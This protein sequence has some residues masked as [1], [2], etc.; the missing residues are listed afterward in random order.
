[1][2]TQKPRTL[3]RMLLSLLTIGALVYAGWA[4]V[5]WFK[6]DDLLFPRRLAGP[7]MPEATFPRDIQRLW[8]PLDGDDRRVT[9]DKPGGESIEAWLYLP[10]GLPADLAHGDKRPAVVF[11]HG[12]GELIDHMDDYARRWLARGFIVLIPEYRGYGR[13]AGLPG[14]D[15][16][17]AD[18]RLFADWLRHRPDVDPARLVYHGRSL[19]TGVV[20][21]LAAA[22]NTS[23][24]PR[25][26]AIV[27]E[28]PFTSVASFAAGFGIP[29]FLVKNP[30]RTDAVLPALAQSGVHVLIVHSPDDEIVHYKHGRRL[31]DITPSA[32]L[33]DLSG[34][35]ISN[36][37]GQPAYWQAVDTLLTDHALTTNPQQPPP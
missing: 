25:P 11:A 35:H 17:V 29:S 34:S 20:S 28:S 9:N 23:T 19:G 7:G 21:Q 4:A 30:F 13:S 2:R 16:I 31:A 22:D 32:R 6:Q 33:V 8:I 3:K 12:N 24:P 1:M 10:P 15:G 14:Q 18:Y 27:L 36:L 37:C 5:L 26:A